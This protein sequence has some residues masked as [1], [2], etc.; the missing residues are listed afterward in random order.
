MNL[1]VQHVSVYN[2]VMIQYIHMVV[3]PSAPPISRALHLAELE[4]CSH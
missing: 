1:T 3:Q 2:S 4:L